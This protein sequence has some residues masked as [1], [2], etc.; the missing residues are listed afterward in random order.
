MTMPIKFQCVLLGVQLPV[1]PFVQLPSARPNQTISGS[2]QTSVPGLLSHISVTHCL[3][4]DHFSFTPCSMVAWC[5]QSKIKLQK[6]SIPGSCG[7]PSLSHAVVANMDTASWEQCHKVATVASNSILAV[8]RLLDVQSI[9]LLADI[10]FISGWSYLL[11]GSSPGKSQCVPEQACVRQIDN[12]CK[13]VWR[14]TP[15]SPLYAPF[16]CL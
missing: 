10:A 3:S 13:P 9:S 6:R 12:A 1:L 16:Y 5:P 7:L 11:P 4:I 15:P 14:N 8:R 2:G